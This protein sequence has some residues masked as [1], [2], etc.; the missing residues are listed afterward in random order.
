MKPDGSRADSQ[1]GGDLGIPQLP[2]EQR[3]HL[4]LAGSETRAAMRF[5]PIEED[6]SRCTRQQA[7]P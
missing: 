6:C 2:G 3:K 1:S 5:Q 4:L 7:A